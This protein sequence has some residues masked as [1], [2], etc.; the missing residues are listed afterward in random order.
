MSQLYLYLVTWKERSGY[1]RYDSFVVCCKSSKEARRTHP[2]VGEIG[3]WNPKD[4]TSE[5]ED[6][7]IPFRDRMKLEV[8][9]IG[10][11]E[12]GMKARIVC[13]SFRAG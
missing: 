6:I 4:E 13:K 2:S 1:D 8:Q 11:A 12:E 5:D 7:W 9:K 10:E 3:G